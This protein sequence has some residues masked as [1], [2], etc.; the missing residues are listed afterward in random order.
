MNFSF[1]LHFNSRIV[2]F[3]LFTDVL[4]VRYTLPMVFL[5]SL[6]ILK[7]FFFKSVNRQSSISP[8][9]SSG[10]ISVHFFSMN[11]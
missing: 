10:I 7:T 6:I 4:L 5:S 3:C 8:W 2:V 9:A 11:G 1:K